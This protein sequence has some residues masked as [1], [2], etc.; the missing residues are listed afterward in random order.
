[1][2]G[3]CSTNSSSGASGNPRTGPLKVGA[4]REAFRGRAAIG[5]LPEQ[6]APAA[7]HATT[8]DD[9]AAVAG[10]CADVHAITLKPTR[11]PA[12][13]VQ[14]VHGWTALLGDGDARA[15]G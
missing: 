3:L 4:C 11:N 12:C 13:Q 10:P 2:A 8:E 5:R 9:P 14:D 6:I 1:M 7:F 15:V